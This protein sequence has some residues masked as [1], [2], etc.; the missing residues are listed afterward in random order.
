[1]VTLLNVRH[2]TMNAA[3]LGKKLT[4]RLIKEVV[5]IISY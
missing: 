2:V 5:G 4:Q 1:M 3:R